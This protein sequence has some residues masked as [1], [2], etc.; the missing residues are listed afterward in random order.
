MLRI[1]EWQWGRY[2]VEAYLEAEEDGKKDE[3]RDRRSDDVG[4]VYDEELNSCG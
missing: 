3:R 4:D 2:T 1:T